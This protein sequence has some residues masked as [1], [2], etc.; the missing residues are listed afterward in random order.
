MST[1][2]LMISS[3]VRAPAGP[4]WCDPTTPSGSVPFADSDLIEQIGRKRAMRFRGG[5]ALAG[6]RRRVAESPLPAP[7]AAAAAP[8]AGVAAATAEAGAGRHATVTFEDER[9][10]P[11]VPAAPAPA[12]A[13]VAAAAE[14]D[15]ECLPG[16]YG[17]VRAEFVGQPGGDSGEE[18][19]EGGP[20]SPGEDG[21]PPFREDELSDIDAPSPRSAHGR[22]TSVAAA[23]AGG[24]LPAV[25]APRAAAAGPADPDWWASSRALFPSAPSPSRRQRGSRGDPAGG[26]SLPGNSGGRGGGAAAPRPGASWPHGAPPY[27][28]GG[29]AMTQAMLPFVS[30]CPPYAVMTEFGLMMSVLVPLGGPPLHTQTLHGVGPGGAPFGVP[31]AAAAAPWQQQQQ[32]APRQRRGGGWGAASASGSSS[33]GEEGSARAEAERRRAVRAL[34]SAAVLQQ[35]RRQNPLAQRQAQLLPRAGRPSAGASPDASEAAG[36]K[37]SGTKRPRAEASAAGGAADGA[38]AAAAGVAAGDKPLAGARRKA[39]LK[40]SIQRHF[41]DSPKRPR[42]VSESRDAAGRAVL[43]INDDSSEPDLPPPPLPA[44]MGG[45]KSKAADAGAKVVGGAAAAPPEAVSAIPVAEDDTP[46]MAERRREFRADHLNAPIVWDVPGPSAPPGSEAPSAIYDRYYR[47]VRARN[48]ALKALRA[49]ASPPGDP[50]ALAAGGP[51]GPTQ[52]TQAELPDAPAPPAIPAADFGALFSIWDA[53]LGPHARHGDTDVAGERKLAAVAASK[54][55]LAVPAFGPGAPQ[56]QPGALRSLRVLLGPQASAAPPAGDDAASTRAVGAVPV[57]AV[58]AAAEGVDA[59][60]AVPLLGRALFAA[61]AAAASAGSKP[62]GGAAAA[63]P[64][65]APTPGFRPELNGFPYEFD[66]TL[67]ALDAAVRAA[68]SVSV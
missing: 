23:A 55:A 15:T 68:V 61:V 7:A 54:A 18:E 5:G 57:T 6:G 29:G 33:G 38:A 67:G 20:E 30:Y 53:A 41:P 51:A 56:Q 42:G 19:G 36:A 4:C 63:A 25:A 65:P 47:A 64:A 3:M 59:D 27:P 34:G 50:D 66:E 37:L 28:Y 62:G 22:P 43:T 40:S 60:P 9:A 45:A 21:G 12:A 58:A 52:L 26:R 2:L 48:R 31:A 32:Q 10:A 11:C 49:V 13:S 24:S 8:L 16:G 39:A 46:E 17:V 1:T 14:A 44:P 35:P